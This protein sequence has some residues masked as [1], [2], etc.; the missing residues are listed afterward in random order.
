MPEMSIILRS[1]KQHKPELPTLTLIAPQS[2]ILAFFTHICRQNVLNFFP[3]PTAA[4]HVVTCVVL[5]TQY[6]PG[7]SFSYFPVF[8]QIRFTSFDKERYNNS[9]QN[10]EEACKY[11]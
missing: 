1:S 10:G 7:F 2:A 11:G 8:C 5:S 4:E 3:A 6:L 9:Y